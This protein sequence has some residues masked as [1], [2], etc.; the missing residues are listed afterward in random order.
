MR[1]CG[2]TWNYEVTKLSAC[3]NKT[4]YKFQRFG[5]L[6]GE[7]WKQQEEQ[8]Y[9]GRSDGDTHDAHDVALALA[10]MWPIRLPS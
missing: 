1:M 6:L 10:G 9:C 5:P 2:V 7:S 8:R 3:A 4:P